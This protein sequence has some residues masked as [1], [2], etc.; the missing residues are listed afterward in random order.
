VSGAERMCDGGEFGLSPVDP[1][2]KQGLPATGTTLADAGAVVLA[3][4]IRRTCCYCRLQSDIWHFVERVF[5][6]HVSRVQGAG[7]SLIS[8][9]DEAQEEGFRAGCMGRR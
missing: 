3:P 7:I 4:S 9:S 8:M 5:E 2:L 6:V 1:W